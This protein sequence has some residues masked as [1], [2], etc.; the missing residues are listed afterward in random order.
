MRLLLHRRYKSVKQM[1]FDYL[2]DLADDPESP[3][4]T[5]TAWDLHQYVFDAFDCTSFY[6]Q[7]DF[8]LDDY[9]A[10]K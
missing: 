6:E 2:C 5:D 1:I 4:T 9:F 3:V 7:I 8:L 10:N